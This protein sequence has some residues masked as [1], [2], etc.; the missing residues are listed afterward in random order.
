MQTK[1]RIWGVVWLVLA[2]LAAWTGSAW[3]APNQKELFNRIQTNCQLAHEQ[4]LLGSLPQ[5]NREALMDLAQANCPRVRASSIYALGEF[6]E[7]RAVRMLI[8]R[9]QDQDP[10]VRRITARALGKIGDRK[11]IAPLV[12]LMENPKEH[13]LVR[14]V[15]AE[16]LGMFSQESGARALKRYS[17]AEP[18][19]LR[20]ARGKALARLETV[21]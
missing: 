1:T 4:G 10:D 9:L 21:Q 12:R 6:Q 17:H 7:S 14:V 3:A 8:G 19:L 5:V 11:G 13:P 15:A 18:P 20:R 16:A 2:M